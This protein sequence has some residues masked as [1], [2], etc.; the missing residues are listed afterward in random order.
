MIRCNI[1]LALTRSIRN[2]QFLER[3]A[4]NTLGGLAKLM[5]HSSPKGIAPLPLWPAQV[6]HAPQPFQIPRVG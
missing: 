6:Y 1:F 2:L 3:L 5:G 4:L